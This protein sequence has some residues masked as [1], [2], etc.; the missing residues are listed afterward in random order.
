MIYHAALAVNE[1]IMI[2][3]QELNKLMRSLFSGNMTQIHLGESL[4]KM[5]A[6]DENSKL[7]LSTKIYSGGNFIPFSVR[8]CTNKTSH[9]SRY[10][11]PTSL[12]IDEQNYQIFLNYR[13]LA[14]DLNQEH[15]T[16]LLEEFAHQADDWRIYL[17]EHDKHDLVY[18][19]V[20]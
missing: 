8:A 17:D 12:L 7:L 3:E 4:I 16:E 6:I 19:P 13:G 5:Q 15:F 14:K 2:A 18:I 10:S 1:V 9:K 11:I 20:K